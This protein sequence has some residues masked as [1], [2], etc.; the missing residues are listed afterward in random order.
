[1]NTSGMT[2]EEKI[3]A[4]LEY[5]KTISEPNEEILKLIRKY[6]SKIQYM[7]TPKLLEPHGDI[8]YG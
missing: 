5:L 4:F 2:V 8:E 3:Q 6:E 1:M 7:N